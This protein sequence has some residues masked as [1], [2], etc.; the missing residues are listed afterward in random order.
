LRRRN[1]K[2]HTMIDG[3]PEI[4]LVGGG[5]SRKSRKSKKSKKS[6]KSR[7]HSKKSRRC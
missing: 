1:L 2:E 6:H 7:K 3:F 5:R 4:T